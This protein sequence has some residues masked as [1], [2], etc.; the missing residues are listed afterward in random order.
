MKNLNRILLLM[1]VINFFCL[2]APYAQSKKGWVT[3]FDG[4]SLDG[5]KVGENAATFSLSDGL[6]KVAGPRAHLFYVGPFQNHS[7]KN[8]E[9]KAVVKTTPGSNSG[10]Y[11]HTEYQERG[12]PE[13]GYEVQVNNSHRDWIRTGSLYDIQDIK[14]SYAKDNE[15]YTQHI[16][17]KGKRIIVKINDTVVIDYTE[18]ENPLRTEDHKYRLLNRGTFAIQGHDAKSVVYYKNI[19]VKLMPD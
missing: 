1:A 15:W 4:S 18:P 12:W 9:F 16:I 10:L 19:Q 17:V 6:L 8:F 2:T 13:K 14:E 7:F 11:I 3:L 5:W